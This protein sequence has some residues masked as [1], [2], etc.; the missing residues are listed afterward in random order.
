MCAVQVSKITL[1]IYITS[2]VLC[3][4]LC[5]NFVYAHFLGIRRIFSENNIIIQELKNRVTGEKNIIYQGLLYTSSE[6][7]SDEF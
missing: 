5:L 2:C 1:K 7:E 6:N 3:L 4:C